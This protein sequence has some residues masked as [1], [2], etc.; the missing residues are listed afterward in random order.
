MRGR[1]VR[2]RESSADFWPGFVDALATL[3]L[4]FMLLM[5]IFMLAKAYQDQ[6]ATRLDD[7]NRQ[8]QAQV[9]ELGRQLAMTRREA[10]RIL[11]EK[12]EIEATLV[13]LQEQA[14]AAERAR[15][16]AGASE[17]EAVGRAQSALDDQR[18]LSA[19]AQ[20]QVDLLNRQIKQLRK[21]ISS[22][23][24]ALQTSE[25]RDRENKA[26][27]ADLGRRLNVALARKVQELS[28]YRS[29]FLAQLVDIIGDR[30]LVRMEGDRFIFQ[31][32]V[33]FASGTAE[34]NPA[35]RAQLR[36]LGEA[37]RQL[38][39]DIP[40]SINWILRVDGHT[41]RQPISSAKY[42]SNWEL[43]VARALSV[44]NFLREEGVPPHRLAAAGFGSHHP[45]DDAR[46]AEAYRKNRRIELKLTER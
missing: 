4:V 19:A 46:T 41:D 33:L 32:E 44:V 8:L 11:A 15:A 28:R 45:I 12:S 3:V 27:I 6:F 25:E 38:E 1:Y 22:L 36:K 37:L 24:A 10:D 2:S 23:Q 20:A 30:D 29:E 18:R 14:A 31:S 39:T 40:A 17:S 16:E 13:Q 43:S 26:T 34:I 5:T 21:Q 35:G 42:P 7:T 9:A